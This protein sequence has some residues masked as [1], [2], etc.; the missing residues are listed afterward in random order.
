MA[1]TT[2]VEE[3]ELTHDGGVTPPTPPGGDDQG[4]AGQPPRVPERA[5]YLGMSLALAAI[6][7]FFM[8]LVSAYMVRK[9]R[10]DWRPID[11]P[12]VVWANTAVLVLSSITL[13]RARKYLKDRD[14]RGFGRWWGVTTAL[15]L[16]F[17]AGQVVA[18]SQLATAGVF[19]ASNPSSSF[20]YLLTG[21]HGVHLLGGVMALVYVSLRGWHFA[22]V[23]RPV[24][25]EVVSIYWHFMDLL[26]V[27]LVLLLSLGR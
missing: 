1:G 22:R 15:G 25:P 26:W 20:F 27:F 21:L 8:A 11:L 4:K 19:L 23:A 17:L 10:G 16:L 2:T 18:W 13:E 5:Y 9:A 6:L 14:A 12:R 3:L 24:A 7:M